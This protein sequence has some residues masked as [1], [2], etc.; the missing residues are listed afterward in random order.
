MMNYFLTSRNE[1]TQSLAE[2]EV[3]E[4]RVLD[5]LEISSN[6]IKLSHCYT[7]M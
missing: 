7:N 6:E 2:V 3:I 5:A 4:F 1:A